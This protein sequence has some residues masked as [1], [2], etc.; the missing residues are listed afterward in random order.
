VRLQRLVL[1][2]FKTFAHRTEIRFEP[3][4]T[5]VVGPNGSGKSNLVDAVRW[6]LG[7]TNARELRGSRLDEMIF[8]GGQGR[9]RMGVAEVE[10]ILDNEKGQL[11][12]ADAEV[13]ISRRVVRGGEVEY[14]VNGERARLRDVER[15]LGGTGLTQHGYAVVAQH[16]IEAIIEATPRQRRSLV[17]QAAGVRPLRVACDDAL[18]RLDQVGAAVQ[19]LTDRL[20]ESEPRLEQL[21]GEREA[22]LE[23]RGVAERLSALRGSLAR[24]E[25][26]AIR[27]E[28][29]LARRRLELAERRL[30]AAN[31]AEAGYTERVDAARAG[32]DAA[33]GA[34]RAAGDR[35]EAARVAA[36]RCRGEARRF[37]DR[38]W[39]AALHRADN[40][41]QARAAAAEIEAAGRALEEV[42]G[43]GREAAE[44]RGELE[45]AA[46]ELAVRSGEAAEAAAGAQSAADEAERVLVRAVAATTAARAGARD[47]AENRDLLDQSAQAAA[48]EL[49]AARARVEEL[50]AVAR[51]AQARLT[52]LE[53]AAGAAEADA[54]SCTAAVEGARRLL[55]EAED[56]S[57]EERERTTQALARAA[58]LRGQV[59]GLLGGSG[60]VGAQAVELDAVRL[61]DAIR[62]VDP[63]DAAAV[64]AALEPHLGAWVVGDVD[65]ALELLRGAEVREE[66]LAAA[67][68]AGTR[69]ADRSERIEPERAAP[70][71]ADPLDDAALVEPMVERAVA[72]ARCAVDAV[73]VQPRARAAA[74][75]CL[76]HTWLVP[77]MAVARR[78]AAGAGARAVLPDGAVITS[79]GA[80]AGG[81]G[82]PTLSMVAAARD[83]AVAAEAATA[84]EAEA[85]GELRRRSAVVAAADQASAHA[86]AELAA[87]RREAAEATAQSAA[88]GIAAAMESRR[89]PALEAELDRRAQARASASAA[90]AGAAL[91]ADRAEQGQQGLRT[92]AEQAH[93]R[94]A[95]LRERSDRIAVE[96]SR[97]D[98]ELAEVRIVA[99]AADR[100]RLESETR[101][102][103]AIGRLAEADARVVGAETDALAAL[104][105]GGAAAAAARV[106]DEAVGLAAARLGETARPLGEGERA[107]SA[108]EAE[109][110]EVRVVVARAEDEVNAARSEV[111]VAEMRLA[112]QAESVRDQVEDD[113]AELDAAA[114]ERAEREIARLERRIAVMGPV[115]ALAPEQHSALEERVGRLRTD[116][117]DLAVASAEVGNLVRRFEGEAGRRFGA[118]FGA[119]SAHFG[120][121]FAELFPGGRAT[122]RL[123]SPPVPAPAAGEDAETAT[124]G[125]ADDDLLGVAILAQP[126]GKRLQP[127]SLLS[128]GERA[129]TA[130]AV[131]LALQQVNPSPFYIF[132]EV[133]APLDDTSVLRFTRL[134]TRL[135]A[136]QQFI[137]VTHNHVTMAAADALYGVTIDRAGVSSLLS[138]RF[139]ADAG[140]ADVTGTLVS[141]LRRVAS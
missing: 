93:L 112:E 105:H 48:A 139:T 113:A 47:R 96:S 14:R 41:R 56:R 28:T 91:E 116:R 71:R 138:V 94:H 121:L 133:D 95:E 92:A 52:E 9:D 115:N 34:Q 124:R 129:L 61:I 64:E 136:I 106:A 70:D 80:R 141:P 63:A 111:G 65:R 18:R 37:A 131:V 127:L 5:G 100:R 21:A 81:G 51:A 85:D 45:P 29:K 83:A 103:E 67:E 40:R 77:D 12:V 49:A 35:L 69:R 4:I 39:T 32:L 20:G 13:A 78:V 125:R 75:H 79:A 108:L 118:V 3:G 44:R 134:L 24:E 82:A 38:A 31:E 72:G 109:R 119:V 50:E 25:W 107:L 130:L 76:A 135:A 114:A 90:A 98:A 7:E 16:D 84:A 73:E 26:R 46:A 17:E 68:V 126:A 43:A 1:S 99:D 62:V 54:A 60:A 36:E 58:S 27:A 2:G 55:R 123:E 88:A 19:R 122:L 101:C 102:R 104:A 6:V 140:I 10:L 137:V 86:S 66:V 8:A 117:D 15:L 120:E 87:R 74:A 132:D 110:G 59:D 42:A 53:A 89:L 22:A 11:P 23:Q 57:V 128:G 33:R 97:A 30:E